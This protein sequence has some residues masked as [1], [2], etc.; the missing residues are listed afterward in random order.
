[1]VHERVNNAGKA[2]IGNIITWEKGKFQV[3]GFQMTVE[4]MPT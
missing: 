2:K 1:M 3:E 4:K